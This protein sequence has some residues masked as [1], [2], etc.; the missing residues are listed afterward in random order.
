LH[1]ALDGVNAHD[2]Q[3]YGLGSPAAEQTRSRFVAILRRA[4][5]AAA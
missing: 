2:V 5:R 3:E 1:A 4:E